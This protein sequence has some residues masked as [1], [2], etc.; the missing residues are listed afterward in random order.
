[1]TLIAAAATITLFQFAA[2]DL[3]ITIAM[4]NMSPFV[5]EQRHY[6]QAIYIFF[7]S[8]AFYL[9]GVYI[10][11]CH[12]KGA[13]LVIILPIFV[14]AS[15]LLGGPTIVLSFVAVLWLMV[16]V[17]SVFK[18]NI[19]DNDT[20]LLGKM[21]AAIP[22][23]LGLF[24]LI[25]MLLTFSLQMKNLLVDGAGVDIPWNEYFKDDTYQ[26]V[27][28]LEGNEKMLLNIQ[29]ADTAIKQQYNTQLKSLK[30]VAIPPEI[31]ALHTQKL[32]PYQQKIQHLTV[33][34]NINRINWVFSFDQM[35]FISQQKHS[36]EVMKL[37]ISDA[38]G[39]VKS[40]STIPTVRT[41]SGLSQIIT[42][43]KIYFYDAD[44]QQIDLRVSVSS[45]ETIISGLYQTGSLM[46]FI[47][48]KN[49]YLFSTNTVKNS[50]EILSPVNVIEIPGAH[51][52]LAQIELA[53]MM[54]S[55]L[56][57]ILFGKNSTTGYFPAEQVL[58]EVDTST[59]HDRILASRPLK[60]GFTEIYYHM[61]WLISPLINW[62]YQQ[63]IKPLLQAEAIKPISPHTQALF[64]KQL[65]LF[66]I[67]LTLAA[68]MLT[69]RYSRHRCKT[70]IERWTW[71]LL[72]YLS[73][74]IGLLTFLLLSDK[75]MTTKQHGI[76]EKS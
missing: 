68:V 17:I 49:I 43:H 30:T 25:G 4:D 58:I 33:V 21:S 48:T 29:H 41:H 10:Q 11:L 44:L 53:E 54:D 76:E 42:P 2:I 75:K 61:G 6:L 40:F 27:V 64:S 51:E 39:N 74:F 46:G 14:I 50:T 24:L 71:V 45:D 36:N 18:A 3:F 66:I 69:M 73:G 63:S 52:N 23:H 19:N 28:Y 16:L 57:S 9:T 20:H 59:G 34:D 32:L 72:T 56:V 62:L 26:H 13:F 65:K 37:G 38:E 8:M 70:S 60:H 12:S 31:N 5:I 47:S 55:T 7:I 67:L 35:L 22:F 15:L 1:M